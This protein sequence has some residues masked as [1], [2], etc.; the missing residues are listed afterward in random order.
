M[1]AF[2]VGVIAAFE[3]RLEKLLNALDPRPVRELN[4]DEPV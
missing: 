4:V 2:A 3:K 1:I